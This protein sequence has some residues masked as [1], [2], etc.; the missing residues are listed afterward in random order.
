MFINTLYR[1]VTWNKP[2]RTEKKSL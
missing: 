2:L 1:H